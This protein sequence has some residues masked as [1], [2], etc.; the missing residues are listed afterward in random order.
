MPWFVGGIVANVAIAI[1]EYYN[2]RLGLGF[3]G[4]LPYTFVFIVIGQWGLHH[5]WSKA[6]DFMVAWIFFTLG[7]NVLRLLSSY[8][9]VGEP[10][11]W[12]QILLTGVMFGCAYGMK[13]WK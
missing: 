13:Y 11:N 6:P 7:N 10:A 2:R 5:Q 9:A 4:T 8:F 3:I 12:K 1:V